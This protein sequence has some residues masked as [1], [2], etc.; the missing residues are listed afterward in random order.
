MSEAR[1][2]KAAKPEKAAPKS[3]KASR[4]PSSAPIMP[5]RR[6]FSGIER[7]TS[8][9]DGGRASDAWQVPEGSTLYD[10][11]IAFMESLRVPEGPLIG[12]PWTLLPYQREVIAALCD[13]NVRRVI[14]SIP[15][16]AGKTAFAAALLLASLAGPLARLNSQVYSAARSRDQASLVFNLAVKI[17]QVTPWLR[18]EIGTVDSR[19]S[20]HGHRFNV[21]YRALA[22][23]AA[24]A[25][26]LG[27]CFVIH[28]ELGQ[29]S[30]AAD[31]LYD[32]LETAFGAQLN[33]KSLIISTQAAEDSDLLSTLIDDARS[34][35][36]PR[37]RVILYAAANTDDPWSEE[38]WK[39]CHP[40]YGLFRNPQE[41]REAADRAQR[42][43]AAEVAFRRYYLN[44]RITGETGFV[45]P[46][47]WKANNGEPDLNIFYD[48]R[49]VYGGLDLSSKQDLTAL[50]LVTE[51]DE[52]NTHAL[53]RAWTPSVTLKDR[54]TRDR[55]P[56]HVWVE[57][58]FL[59]PTPGVT[60]SYEHVMIDI[61]S[62]TDGMNLA[63]IAYDRWRIADFQREMARHGIEFPLN[64]CG[65]GF[66]D[67][68]PRVEATMDVLLNERMRH[69]GNP[70]LTFAAS[71]ATMTRDPA[72]NQKL[73]K[74]R[75]NGRIDPLVAL[76]MAVG[77]MRNTI[78]GAAASI[79]ILVW[80]ANRHA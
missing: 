15:R 7:S 6:S 51:D 39:K 11:M 73:D 3:A 80:G 75:A 1:K 61:A 29:V 52:G 72:G 57:Q 13:P 9:F 45:T 41:F 20:I 44:Q 2:I 78:S 48:G 79:P 19:K 4:A 56:Y 65:Q 12:Q 69:G 28:D 67:M 10:E 30:G 62:L 76:V 40:A 24:N 25:H 21:Q 50:A 5:P 68:S 36:D 34:S 55:A 58:G 47:V 23:D 77:E 26:G 37:T 53:I 16:K 66:R 63:S 31:D 59:I 42:L 18:G 8:V 14:V 35:G 49:P 60:V 33:P 70:V 71:S 46:T 32:A 64:V 74:G 17:A 43:P 38:T 27:P 22:A 54:A